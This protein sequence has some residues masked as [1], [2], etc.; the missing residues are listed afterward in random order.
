LRKDW[1]TPDGSQLGSQ[2]GD[3]GYWCRIADWRLARQLEK[4]AGGQHLLKKKERKKKLHQKN[5]GGGKQTMRAQSVWFFTGEKGSSE[6][7]HSRQPRGK[8][9]SDVSE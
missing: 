8:L 2:G 9:A 3:Q 6:Q 5:Q 1:E 4:Q 7:G